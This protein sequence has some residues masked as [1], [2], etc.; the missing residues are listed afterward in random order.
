VSCALA[1]QACRKGYRAVYR[2]APRFFDE[3]ALA[4]ADGSYGRLLARLARIDVLVIDDWGLGLAREQERCD[5]LEV[6]E[7]RLGNRS[8]IMTSQRPHGKW[9]ENL[10]DPT[11][12]A[13]VG[14]RILLGA[15]RLALTAPSRR[16]PEVQPEE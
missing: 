8:T 9:H 7:D 6:L 14:A 5:L 3:L 4:R 16:K 13:A 10:G 2:R 1:Q 15:P 11:L 12:A